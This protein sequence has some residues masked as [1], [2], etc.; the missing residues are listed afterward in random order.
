[1]DLAAIERKLRA[2][3][4]GAI[5]TDGRLLRRLIKAHRDLPGLGLLVPHASCYALGREALVRLIDPSLLG[6]SPESLPEQVI[7]VA[8]P[9]QGELAGR[10]GEDVLARLW[11]SVF[12]AQIHLAIEERFESGALSAAALRERIDRIGQIEF[13]E[14]RAALRSDDRLLPPGGDREVYTEFAALYLELRHFAPR[15]L[16]TMFPGLSADGKICSILGLD[17]DIGPLLDRSFPEGAERAATVIRS[18]S[19]TSTTTLFTATSFTLFKDRPP[20]RPSPGARARLSEAAE[21]AKRK[22]NL[23]RAAMLRFIAQGA[24]PEE[25]A[26]ASAAAHTDLEILSAR[27]TAALEPPGGGVDPPH[28]VRRAANASWTPLLAMLAEQAAARR[29]LRYPIE[30]RLLF[31]LQ[32]AAIAHERPERAVDLVTWA[33][34]RGEQPI[35]RPLPATR[36][37]KIAR[38][39]HRAAR[40]VRHVRIA[41]ADRKLLAKLLR[42]ASERAEENVRAAL[43]PRL[44]DA[45]AEVGLNP[46]NLPERVARGKLIEELLD[47]VVERGFISLGHLR[48]AV[49]RNQLKL[50]SL[51]SPSELLRGDALLRLDRH[52]AASLDGVYRGGEIYL[53][54]LQKVSSIA[55]GTSGGRMITLYAVLPLLSAFVILEGVSHIVG[56]ASEAIGLGAVHL[57]TW[58]SFLITAA[59][60]FG[61]LHSEVFRAVSKRAGAVALHVLAVVFF[62]VPRWIFSQPSVRR[63]LASPITRAVVRR[64][65]VPMGIAA[66]LTFL[67]PLHEQAAAVAISGAVALFVGFFGI[68]SSPLGTM[69][70]DAFFDWIGPTLTAMGRHVFPGLFRLITETFRALMDLLERMIYQVDEWLRFREGEHRFAIAPKA[71]F[72]LLWFAVAYVIRLYITLLVE[73][74]INPLKHFPVVTVSHKLMLPFSPDVLLA[75]SAALEPLGP[76]IGGTIAATTVFLLPSA[77]GFLVWEFKENWK[78]YRASR[79]R[80]LSPTLIGHHGET[81]GALMI[82]GFH[83]GTLPKLYTRWRRAAQREDEASLGRTPGAPSLPPASEGSQGSFRE[84]IHELEEAVRRFVEREFVTL[85]LRVPRWS[86][87]V[88][89]VVG[90]ELGSN[91][92]RVRLTCDRLDPRPTEIAFEEQSGL[93][94]ASVP[95][96]GFLDKLPEGSDG[97]RLL[98]NALAGLY[99]LAG[100]DVSREQIEDALGKDTPYDISDEGLVAWP[101]QGYRTEVVYPLKDGEGGPQIAPIVRGEPPARPPA[102]LPKARLLF[103]LQPIAWPSWVRA[104]SAAEQ[105]GVALPRLCGG[106]SILPQ[107]AS[108][109]SELVAQGASF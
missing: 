23:V 64:G 86:F 73:P 99:Q 102:S 61:L 68:M 11:R 1:M 25:S 97:Q 96:A 82:P 35:V 41:S 22:G 54:G 10:G 60:L 101:G 51:A 38:H 29:F 32:R 83:S 4:T 66:A 59:F 57:L 79:P 43:R 55:F 7:L 105:P 46:E 26:K 72:G 18:P 70:E 90:I 87:G 16:A 8:R 75:L 20:K 47:Q 109:T 3:K 95:R 84:G 104:W 17:V 31:D 92:I 14:I 63:L 19:R 94:I 13:D 81:M 6:H 62:H 103:R 50:E 24:S 65:L 67:T 58:P 52:L 27:L 39:V 85:L 40:K 80:V 2:S 28:G 45:L 69:I 74:E 100:V 9:S 15:L 44:K 30:A 12:H 36:E 107:R 71:A 48:D 76:V 42:W 5:V 108:Q 91:R 98:E 56:P 88:I 33:L 89:E 37:T 34:S 106:A 77:A 21:E 93:L 49:S 53:R 78:L